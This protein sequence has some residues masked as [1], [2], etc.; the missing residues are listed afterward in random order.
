MMN[1]FSAFRFCFFNQFFF[2]SFSFCLAT[3][4]RFLL[5]GIF[6]DHFSLYRLSF[7]GLFV[8]L[9]SVNEIDSHFFFFENLIFS[10]TLFIKLFVQLQNIHAHVIPISRS[11]QNAH[12]KEVEEI[13]N[14]E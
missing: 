9:P 7:S 2:F 13:H 3:L 10:K 6:P 4:T 12:A 1:Q 11:P 14:D 8:S 5:S